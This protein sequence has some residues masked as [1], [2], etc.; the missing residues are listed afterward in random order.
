MA[1]D[2]RPAYE[3]MLAAQVAPRLRALGFADDYRR[4]EADGGAI[5]IDFVGEGATFPGQVAF[6]IEVR[7]ATGRWVAYARE[8]GADELAQVWGRVAPP[9]GYGFHLGSDDWNLRTAA[10]APGYGAEVSRLL[11]DVVVPGLERHLAL[12]AA[13][14]RAVAEGQAV[15]AFEPPPALPGIINRMSYLGPDDPYVSWL[16]GA[17]A[18]RTRSD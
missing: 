14:E 1:V 5:A 4:R 10:D 6:A 15:A 13:L 17:T 11:S 7:A 8:T 12:N 18:S 16:R 3:A 9:A 2:V